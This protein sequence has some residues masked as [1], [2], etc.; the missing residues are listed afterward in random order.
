MIV[1][2][3]KIL[4]LFRAAG[5]CEFCG[6]SLPRREPHHVMSR[7]QSGGTRLDIPANL[8]GLCPFFKGNNCHHLKG[9]DPRFRPRFLDIICKREGF[10]SGEAVWDW[11]QM[12]LGLPKYSE[13]PAMPVCPF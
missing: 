2:N 6:L 5:D 3:R 8:V 12:V 10:D 13:L 4:E 7:G 9:D 11:L 1:K